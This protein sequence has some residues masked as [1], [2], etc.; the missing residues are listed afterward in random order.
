MKSIGVCLI[1]LIPILAGFLHAAA[2]EKNEKRKAALIEFLDEIRFQIFNYD[3]SQSEIYENFE[4]KFL[5]QDGFLPNL[6]E[7]AKSKPWGAFERALKVFLESTSFS[8]RA[9]LSLKD[10]AKR[11]GMQSKAAQISDLEETLNCLREEEKKEA[12]GI[13]NR[14]KIAR[15]TGLTTGLGIFI[16]LI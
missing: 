15:M 1:S 7:E 12:D 2:M 14:A 16:L 10:F 5:E 8:P 11:F 9:A 3:R 13:R 4:N 6:R